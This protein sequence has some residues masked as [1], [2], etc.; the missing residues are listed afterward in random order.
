MNTSGKRTAKCCFTFI[1]MMSI[2]NIHAA[3]PTI[4]VNVLNYV[5]AKSALH[6]SNVV[7]RSGG[8]N[9]WSHLRQPTPLDKQRISRMNR[10]T[11]YSS[12]LVDISKGASFSL[13][14][15]GDRYM[16]ATVINEE[17]YIN[18]IY[19]GAG[20]YHLTVNEFDSP[21]VL[22]T[23]RT[24][25]NASDPDDIKKA[26]ALQDK[27]LLKSASNKLYTHPNYDQESLKATSK[28]LSQ[29]AG[30]L[31]DVVQTY[32]RKENVNKVRHMLASAYGWG[33]L[34][35]SEV[36]YLNV[37]PN[38]PI[39]DFSLTVGDV[40]VDG[41]WSLSVY[42][43]DGFFE[44]NEYDAYSVNNLTAEKSPDG[45][46]T[47]NFGGS[48]QARNFLPITEGWNYVVRMYR[49]RLDIVEGRWT[50]PQLD[51]VTSSD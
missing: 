40:P 5:K 2:A 45:S 35:E 16:S 28:P 33:G 39:G 25:V 46:V 19:H 11:L 21:F 47:V 30:G 15:S 43:K 9:K 3:E 27:L 44:K 13:P 1:V 51:G 41:F 37:Q 50:F 14:D 26:N 49:P 36:I 34:P 4:K 24:L 42:N 22:L 23:V 29:L 20:E 38:L 32:G 48:P 12:V 7:K 6:F 8:V 17:H 18:N 10:D 31:P